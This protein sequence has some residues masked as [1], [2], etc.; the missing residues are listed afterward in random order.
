[1][2]TQLQDIIDVYV[3]GLL[4]E[5][6]RELHME[7]G[8]RPISST[9]IGE[10]V[11]AS[12]LKDM[13]HECNLASSHLLAYVN[14]NTPMTQWYETNINRYSDHFLEIL[15][16]RAPYTADPEKYANIWGNLTSQ[17]I[18]AVVG[19]IREDGL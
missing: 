17:L 11:E 12:V 18:G 15:P 6:K 8:T 2:Q 9:T 1:M 13:E 19:N 3:S 10:K 7:F 5:I 14:M 16:I 4:F